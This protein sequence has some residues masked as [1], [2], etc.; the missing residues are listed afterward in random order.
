MQTP[1]PTAGSDIVFSNNNSVSELNRGG[2]AFVCTMLYVQSLSRTGTAPTTTQL[3]QPGWS[4]VLT[5]EGDNYG[6]IYGPPVQNPPN[7]NVYLF[8]SSIVQSHHKIRSQYVLPSQPCSACA[9]EVHTLLLTSE[10]LWRL[11]TEIVDRSIMGQE[12]QYHVHKI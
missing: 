12:V 2:G 7:P 10:L 3:S 11:L 5:F 4:E 9:K 1:T 6:V 8:S